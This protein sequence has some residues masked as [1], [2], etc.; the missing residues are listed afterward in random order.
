[1]YQQIL[2]EVG[3]RYRKKSLFLSQNFFTYK[4]L[5][6]IFYM[7][8]YSP[9][10]LCSIFLPQY[11]IFVENNMLNF[12][13]AIITLLYA[14]RRQIVFCRARRPSVPPSFRPLTFRIRSIFSQPL[15]TWVNYLPGRDNMQNVYLNNVRKRSRSH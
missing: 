4:D 15:E 3:I 2:N 1:M 6:F 9:M 14:R 5:Y 12:V 8:I 11:Y 10:Q 13:K 7:E